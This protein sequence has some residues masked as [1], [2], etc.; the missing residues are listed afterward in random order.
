[1]FDPFLKVVDASDHGEAREAVIGM[2]ESWRILFVV[3]IAF[4][5]D[6]VRIISTRKAERKER[7]YSDDGC[8]GTSTNAKKNWGSVKNHIT[9]SC[10]CSGHL[11]SHRGQH[12]TTV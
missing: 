12:P 2:D 7:K 1:M 3:H 8:S 5:E 10:G 11:Q 9:S 4:E 6:V